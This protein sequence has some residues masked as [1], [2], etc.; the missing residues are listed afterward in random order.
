MKT[1]L[2]L[3]ILAFLSADLRAQAPG[4]ITYQGRVTNG[5]APFTGT[6][7]FRFVIYRNGPPTSLW[8]HDSSS[9]GGA[10]PVTAVSLPVS[11]GLFSV[12]LG[13]TTVPGMLHPIVSAI[14]QNSNLRVRIWFSDGVIAPAV[15][16]DHAITSTGYAFFAMN[17][18]D[19]SITSAKIAGGA[20]G[21][22]QL[23]NDVTFSQLRL[24][25][26]GTETVSL[27]AST[28]A[29]EG[30]LL[31]MRNGLGATTV[32]L[33]SDTFG[34]RGSALTLFN[35]VGVG[36]ITLNADNIG[37]SATLA[38]RNSGNIETVQLLSS[39]G[40]GEGAVLHLRNGLSR[41]TLTLDADASGR[42]GAISLTDADGDV[43]LLLDG[44]EDGGV[45][46][47]IQVFNSAGARRAELDGEG[48]S[49]GG[50]LVLDDADGTATVNLRGAESATTGARLDLFHA[51]G[52]RTVTLDAQSGAGGGAFELFESGGTR[53]VFLNSD[54]SGHAGVLGLYDATG[55]LTVLMDADEGDGIGG[56]VQVFNSAGAIRAEL[57]GQSAS[58]GGEFILRDEDGT[59]TVVIEAAEGAGNGAQIALY[60]GA[61]GGAT[62]VLDADQGGEGRITTQVLEITGG[63]DFSE[64]FDIR[65][66]SEAQPGML[67][68]IDTANPG[69]LAV[70]DGAYDRAVAGVVSG[71]GGVRPG[72]LMGQRASIADGRHPVAL[73]GR[74]YCLVDAGRGAIEP[75]DLITTSDT[76]GHG[77]KASD[78]ARTHGAVI[79]KAMT[80]LA[81][82]RGL[83]L[84]LVSLQ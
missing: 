44:E 26:S 2:V 53:T 31:T 48:A 24:D 3:A 76:P 57:D 72:L 80:G 71:A 17:V 39:I 22:T 79:G 14:F 12:G 18:P 42:A 69:E 4:I 78:P 9:A 15:I 27:D 36:A 74:V 13:D 70:S 60:R 77:M 41:T 34:E 6:G 64:N 43:T 30:A 28:G 84:V 40:V 47:T 61:G 52:T 49:G 33:D 68:K 35:S 32:S 83:I 37:E 82:G 29:G 46:G 10:M 73:T 56:T 55:D 23:A 66:K 67:V 58:G 19:A 11:G 59:S 54:G 65:G 20:V 81:S 1:K 62:I 7:Q 21:S 51:D 25:E 45:G 38:L 8:S 16:A 50:E 5:G 75:G 63:S